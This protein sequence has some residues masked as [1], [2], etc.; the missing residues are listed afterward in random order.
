MAGYANLSIWCNLI[1]NWSN[2]FG[3]LFIIIIF[4]PAMQIMNNTKQIKKQFPDGEG[5]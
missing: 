3:I 4:V 2:K 1:L 5:V